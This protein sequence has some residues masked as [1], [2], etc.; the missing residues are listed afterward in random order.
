MLVSNRTS[1][2]G[3]GRVTTQAVV[4]SIII[5]IVADAILNYFLLFI[6]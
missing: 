3:A 2:G 5:M 6:V 4:V 1:E